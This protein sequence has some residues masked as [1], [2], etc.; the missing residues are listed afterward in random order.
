MDCVDRLRVFF[1]HK[2]G[3]FLTGSMRRQRKKPEE[4]S[5]ALMKNTVG[6]LDEQQQDSAGVKHVVPPPPTSLLQEPS[7]TSAMRLYPHEIGKYALHI[8][9]PLTEDSHDYRLRAFI[10]ER[11]RAARMMLNDGDVELHEMEELHVSLTR[12]MGVTLETGESILHGL[13]HIARNETPIAIK[14]GSTLQGFLNENETRSF[15]AVP[16]L[17][18]GLIV[19]II[20]KI[21]GLLQKFN[22]ETFHRDPRPHVSFAWASE[23]ILC[24]TLNEKQSSKDVDPSA[25]SCTVLVNHLECRIGSKAHCFNFDQ[26]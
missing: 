13:K 21:D 4:A 9:L 17:P 2:L 19:P 26:G 14:L 16:V 25:A 10:L 15:A 24:K 5:R 12:P 6:C 18:P 7:K 11:T 20:K 3:I 8:Y 22:L 1:S 23:D